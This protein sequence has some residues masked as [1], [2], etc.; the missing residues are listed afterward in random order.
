PITYSHGAN[1][2]LLRLTT[3]EAR[4][5]KSMKTDPSYPQS[6]MMAIVDTVI[7]E[8]GLD[9]QRYL[10]IGS[11][12]PDS[13]AGSVFAVHH[14]AARSSDQPAA[15]RHCA[16]AR[17]RSAADW[18]RSCGSFARQ[19]A[20]TAARLA[21]T[22]GRRSVSAGGGSDRCAASNWPRGFP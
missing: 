21:G 20:T 10:C 12:G 4:A 9:I 11:F 15:H 22:S 2:N 13:F 14:S 18:K 16:S 19:Q 6:R 5:Q 1:R 8:T 17:S 7:T 3:S